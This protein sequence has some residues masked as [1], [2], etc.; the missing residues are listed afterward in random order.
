MLVVFPVGF[1]ERFIIR[2]L[3]RKREDVDGLEPG[4]TLLA[5]VP[6][7]YRSEQRTTNAINAIKNIASPII[8]EEHIM[9]LEVP[10][11]GEEIV[12]RISQ[13]IKDNLTDDRLILAVLSGGM[14]PLIVS[15]LLALLNIEDVRVIVESDFENLSGH[16]SLELGL[17][18]APSNRRW[19]KIICGFLEGKSVR[20]ISEELG[21]SPAT[22]SNELKEMTKYGLVKAEKLDGRAP[23]YK[24][25]N[26][27]RLYL[28]I[29][30]ENCHED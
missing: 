19:A 2:A 20:K 23:R 13:A 16:I 21:V 14:R 1:D 10:L 11:N 18:L 27:G 12:T 5:I 30:G 24:A 15:T 8:G 17:F 22:I 25:T 3:V 29:K 9:I 7:G 26:A 28:K 4:D 6:E